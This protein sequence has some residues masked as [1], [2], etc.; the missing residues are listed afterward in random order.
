MPKY[1][2]LM[3]QTWPLPLCFLRLLMDRYRAALASVHTPRISHP[4]LRYG[5]QHL[6]DSCHNR[7]TL[8][9]LAQGAL[10]SS[11]RTHNMLRMS[12]ARRSNFSKLPGTLRLW[13]HS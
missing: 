10:H 1:H 3:R 5:E 7:L 11:R 12:G 9:R 6:V 2:S 8:P 4:Y 13:Q